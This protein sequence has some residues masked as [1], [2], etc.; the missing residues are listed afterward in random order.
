MSRV[1]TFSAHLTGGSAITLAAST[2]T[3]LIG[4]TSVGID[5]TQTD[6][7]NI[8]LNNTG[9][10]TIDTVTLYASSLGF[11]FSPIGGNLGPILSG[12]LLQVD[13][14]D[15][16]VTQI[17]ITATSTTG[18]TVEIEAIGSRTSL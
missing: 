1:K 16:D 11:G 10:A 6:F 9:A 12:A 13:L 15:I 14:S 8:T 17:R 3:D 4:P 5:V 7:L 2:E 18:S